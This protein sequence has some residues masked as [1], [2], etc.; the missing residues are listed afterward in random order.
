MGI[1]Y[2]LNLSIK[3]LENAVTQLRNAA[4]WF[5]EAEDNYRGN[6]RYDEA[7]RLQGDLDRLIAAR[8]YIVPA[9]KK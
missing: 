7:G 9:L 1:E 2:D 6:I 3:A 8:D 5:Y 4:A